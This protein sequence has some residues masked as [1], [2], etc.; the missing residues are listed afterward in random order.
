MNVLKELPVQVS[1]LDSEHRLLRPFCPHWAFVELHTAPS[2]HTCTQQWW[3][4]LVGRGLAAHL[5]EGLSNGLEGNVR[6]R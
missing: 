4:L 6:T 3:C 1:V 2:Y 5:E